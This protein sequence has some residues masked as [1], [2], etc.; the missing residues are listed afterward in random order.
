MKIVVTGGA[1]FI[2]ANLCRRLVGH[3][4]VDHVAGAR[5]P[6]DRL[7][8]QPRRR[9]RRAGRGLD[10]RH[11]PAR[12]VRR[13]RRRHRAPRRPPVGAPLGRRPGRQP[14][15]QRHRHGQRARSG[16]GR[17]R[18]PGRR[19][20]VLLGLRRQ[21]D[22]AQA[23]GPGHPAAQPLRRLAS[24]PPRPTPWPGSRPTTCPSWPSGSSTCS[25]RSRPP[26]TPTPRSSPPSS[27][28]RSRET[29]SPCTATAPR[30]RDFTYVD[31][32]TEV[33]ATAAVD[34]VDHPDPGQPGV[35]QPHRPARTSSSCSS[36]SSAHPLERDHQ[37]TRVGDVK[38]SQADSSVLVSLFPDVTPVDLE[39]GLRRT[40]E[41]FQ[42]LGVT[43][44]YRG[45][46]AVDLVLLV[47]VGS[48]GAGPGRPLRPR[49]PVHLTR[50]G[51]VPP[52]TH[53]ARRSTRSSSSSSAPC[54]SA[55][56][57]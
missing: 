51:A 52:G 1:G 3:P 24:S 45:K 39:T 21:P 23:R 16:P 32:V 38:Q 30:R 11:R 33:L 56:T 50:S 31:T 22:A 8:L 14:P 18:A 41:W 29:R 43:G 10:P 15:G 13:R 48:P 36:R 44:P 34:G 40:V 57:R 5:R 47:V 46:R 20:L 12:Q 35:R 27:T 2:G 17:R 54:S 7:P 26:D 53:R 37:P 25:G 49:R 6:L 28:P 4:S 9:R 42:S 19:R 55:T